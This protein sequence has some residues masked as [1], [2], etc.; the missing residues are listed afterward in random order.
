MVYPCD[1]DSPT[2]RAVMEHTSSEYP[3]AFAMGEEVPVDAQGTEALRRILAGPG[4]VTNPAVS[5]KSRDRFS[6][7]STIAIAVR[8]KGDRPYLFAL[9]Q[10]SHARDWNA[11]ERRLFEEI[12]RRLE[13]AL[14]SVLAHRK[15]LQREAEVRRLVDANIVGIVFWDLDGGIR[16]ANDAFLRMTGYERAD[17]AS[18]RLRWTDL[19]PAEWRERD[20]RAVA[21]LNSNGSFLPFEKEYF[22]KDGSRVSVF[23]GGALFQEGG[24]EGV[25]FVLDLSEQKRAQEALRSSEA[26]LAEA[27]TL[28]QT[29][30]WAW[31]PDQDIRYWSEECYRVLSFDPR[32][33]LPRFE[34]FFQ[35]IHPDDQPGF[36]ELTQAATREKA[37]WKADYRIVH[38]GGAVRN[39]H[40][41]GHPVLNTSGDLVEFVGTVIDVTEP[42]R[43]EEDLRASEQR[44][45]TFVDQATDAFFLYD[46]KH[47]VRDVNRR[48]CETMGY[49]RDELIGMHV[50]QLNPDVTPEMLE[51]QWGRL[52]E[53]GTVTHTGLRRRKDGSVFPVELRARVFSRGGRFFAIASAIDITERRRRE[54]CV[55]AQHRVTQVLSEAATL[56][57]A[58]SG[59]L[60]ALCR[61][62][63]CDFGVAW[64]V[65]AEARVLKCVD[66][67]SP[68]SASRPAFEAAT[69]AATFGPGVELP[70]RA[71]S[72][73]APVCVRDIAADPSSSRAE[74]AASEGFHAAFAFPIALKSGIT[75][76]IELFSREVRDADPELLQMM[77]TVGSQAG[78]FVERSR[79]EDALRGAHSELAHVTR[80]MSMGE[81]TAS[82]AHEVNQ[83]LGAMVTSA[84]SA[85]RWLAAKPPNLE[86]AWLALAR[87]AADG[88]RASKVIDRMR[89]LVKRQGPG[90]QPVDVNETIGSVVTLMR[91]ELER[92]GVAHA[93]RLA[94]DLPRVLGDR[95]LLQQVIL[96]LILNAIDA[97]R[98]IEDRARVLRIESRLGDAGEV[99]VQVRDTGSGLPPDARLFQAFYTTKERGLGMGLSISRSI[100]EE[101]GGRMQA[102][103]NEPHGAL[104]EFSLPVT[105]P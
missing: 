91:D 4:A 35:R 39:I 43:A 94:D 54:Q 62:L 44:F 85:S 22:R 100:V 47:I 1:P 18:V 74:L 86:K 42:K 2:V 41:V 48:A 99:W 50:S 32:D 9:H 101:H 78:Q 40:V 56:E 102:R 36:R 46:D 34:Q 77:M 8:P 37:E 13:D 23:I 81:L 71:W 59:V 24:T 58:R 87:I 66:T 31:S 70:G 3:R 10:C 80:V 49:T 97:M 57:Q 89:M 15:L 98:G 25:A 95:V 88:E 29:G 12:A 7:K 83:P 69:R 105:Q 51:S 21:E 61:A 73:G 19:T 17:L 38:P 14:T 28:S 30:S 93:V 76:V 104:F 27:Q 20:E 90:R 11:A 84:A 53:R 6:I 52:L 64:C 60:H 75:G 5:P 103:P 33:G 45:R 92:A 65:D 68:S 55:L 72:R 96:N 26:Y 63:E 82:I 79:A 67:W 16:D